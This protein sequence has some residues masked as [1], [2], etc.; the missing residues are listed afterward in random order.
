MEISEDGAEDP[1]IKIKYVTDEP[2]VDSIYVENAGKMYPLGDT[3]SEPTQDSVY[4]ENGS[5]VYSLLESASKAAHSFTFSDPAADSVNIKLVAIDE[6]GNSTRKDTSAV[7]D[8]AM[9]YGLILRGPRNH[10]WATNDSDA[11]KNFLEQ[12]SYETVLLHLPSE[13]EIKTAIDDIK[14]KTDENDEIV[15]NIT[16]HGVF[17]GIGGNG[18]IGIY[19]NGRDTPAEEVTDNWNNDDYGRLTFLP[20][21]SYGKAIVDR[22]SMPRSVSMTHVWDDESPASYFFNNYYFSPA[23]G[24]IPEITR[25]PSATVREL[26]TELYTDFATSTLHYHPFLGI[27]GDPAEPPGEY[28]AYSDKDG[29]IHGYSE[30]L[31]RRAFRIPELKEE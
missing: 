11:L 23:V 7:L 15:F 1:F 10:D 31:D 29:V 16:C 14:D 5:K 20:L 13:A 6:A 17:G 18:E 28:Q 25:N 24:V 19:S 26:F 9:R 4:V 3:T 2:S 21:I 27:K 30:L 22:T 12:R 8:A